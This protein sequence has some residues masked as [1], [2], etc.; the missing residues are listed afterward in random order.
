MAWPFSISNI[1]A[2][3]KAEPLF[4]RALSASIESVYRTGSPETAE[5][6]SNLAFLY[7][8]MQNKSNALAV[9]I[10]AEQ[11]RL[12]VL[13]SILSFTGEEQRLDYQATQDPYVV[14]ATLGDG[15]R[16]AAAVLHHKGVVL[17]SLLEDGLV[18]EASHDPTC[19]PASSNCAASSS[20]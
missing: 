18:A 5:S 6:L 2:F 4:Q 19:A 12:K 1:G 9:N 8:A 17:D 10:K 11:S 3:A 15:L 16:M 14:F 20:N 13:S 7:L